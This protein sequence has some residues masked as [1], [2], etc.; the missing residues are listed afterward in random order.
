MYIWG[1]VGV[2]TCLHLGSFWANNY[3][4][5]VWSLDDDSSMLYMTHPSISI[6]DERW[7][8]KDEFV[9]M[10]KT[11]C[12]EEGTYHTWVKRFITRN[13]RMKEQMANEQS[14]DAYIA[15]ASKFW[16]SFVCIRLKMIMFL[17][18]IKKRKFILQGHFI[19]LMRCITYKD[20]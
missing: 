5:S 1:C 2:S 13:K 16:V 10:P 7:C 3:M 19:N 11:W 15:I 18:L 12:W 20:F 14:G 4:L 17:V 9:Y 8:S 6:C